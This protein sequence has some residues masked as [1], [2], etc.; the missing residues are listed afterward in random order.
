MTDEDLRN[1]EDADASNGANRA[2]RIR[3]EGE[4]ELAASAIENGYDL[5][6]SETA[7][8]AVRTHLARVLRHEGPDDYVR[9]VG[10]M[11]KMLQEQKAELD[12][13]V[14]EDTRRWAN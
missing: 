12:K 6:A 10:K 7:F 4:I 1:A 11:I 2:R 8:H 3:I 9:F 14:A 13:A 5:N